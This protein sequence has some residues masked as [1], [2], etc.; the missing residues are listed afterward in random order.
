M[1]FLIVRHILE[2]TRFSEKRQKE[3]TRGSP[4]SCWTSQVDGAMMDMTNLEASLS[5]ALALCLVDNELALS[6]GSTSR[7]HVTKVDMHV[8]D[9]SH[10]KKEGHSQ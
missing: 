4:W 1:P 8:G 5:L 7:F 2:I 10:G 3:L 6:L 9:K